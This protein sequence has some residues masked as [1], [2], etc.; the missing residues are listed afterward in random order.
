VIKTDEY[1]QK[2]LMK[3]R[4]ISGTSALHCPRCLTMV[5][6]EIPTPEILA[7]AN[8][9]KRITGKTPTEIRTSGGKFPLRTYPCDLCGTLMEDKC[10]AICPGCKWVMPCSI[11]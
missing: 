11:G 3:L 4:R 6:S 5:P 10:G 9:V 2:C 8:E 1:C 7:A